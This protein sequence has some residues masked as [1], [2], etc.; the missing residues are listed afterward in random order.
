MLH[1]PNC[2]KDGSVIWVHL[3]SGEVAEIRPATGVR[4]EDGKVIILDGTDPICSFDR[5]QGL[6]RLR[7]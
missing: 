3:C 1:V 6:F 7:R 2:G 5:D 4:I